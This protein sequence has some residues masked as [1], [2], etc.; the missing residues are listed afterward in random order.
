MNNKDDTRRSSSRDRSEDDKDKKDDSISQTTKSPVEETQKDRDEDSLEDDPGEATENTGDV[1]ELREELEQ[2]RQSVEERAA[3]NTAEAAV[4]P[5]PVTTSV[6]IRA[7]SSLPPQDPWDFW[8]E[9]LVD[10]NPR[11]AWTEGARGLGE[12]ETLSFTFSNRPQI[13]CLKIWNGYQYGNEKFSGYTPFD[14][15]ASVARFEARVNGRVDSTWSLRDRRGD[16][17]VCLSTAMRVEKL[18]LV[19]LQAHRGQEWEDTCVSEIQ[20]LNEA[21]EEVYIR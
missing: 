15:N 2:L 13:A 16:Q 12:G 20:F 4:E 19:I 8:P 9:N 5:I 11:T 17:I 14:G 6:T 10:G 1:D 7:S 18:E 21:R 3:E